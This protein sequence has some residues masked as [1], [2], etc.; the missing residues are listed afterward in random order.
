MVLMTNEEVYAA[1]DIAAGGE[2]AVH[3]SPALVT[4][5]TDNLDADQKPSHWTEDPVASSRLR[6]ILWV[7]S[8]FLTLICGLLTL[9]RSCSH[10]ETITF[11][12]VQTMFGAYFVLANAARVWP[13]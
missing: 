12:L 4:T 2:H 11:L 13:K 5:C 3:F 6:L 8:V 9:T 7:M 1:N 10:D